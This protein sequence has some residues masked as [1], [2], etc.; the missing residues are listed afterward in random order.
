MSYTSDED[1]RCPIGSRIPLD[2][3]AARD[4]AGLRADAESL[5]SDEEDRAEAAQVLGDMETLHTW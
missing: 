1:H 3:D 2:D 4:R 5:A